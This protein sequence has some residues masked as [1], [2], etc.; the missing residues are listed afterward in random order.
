MPDIYDEMMMASSRI[1]GLFPQARFYTECNRELNISRQVF[2]SDTTVLRCL[3]IVKG[4][5][6]D[7][8]GHGLEHATKV[9]V[10]A[11]ALALTELR[12]VGL[13]DYPVNRIGVLAQVTGLL[14]D[15]RR[16]EKDHA[17]K[18]ARAAEPIIETLFLSRHEQTYVIQAIANHEAF[19]E[20]TTLDSA[21][22]QVLSDVL[23]DA[24]KFRWGPDNFTLTLWEMLRS[25][26]VQ[27]TT[28]IE[29]FP[30]GMASIA[31]IRGTFRSQAG[32]RFG[33]E[34]I[35]VGLRIGEEI[36]RFLQERF[37]VRPSR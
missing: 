9:A 35:D 20:P 30:E 36:Y 2:A 37:A 32:K 26:P 31:R 23:Y 17:K 28:V 3:E 4:G 22:G 7:N 27:M 34:F 11:G 24:D 1:A 29:Q 10:E 13:C 6:N 12:T 14:H 5:L 15:I 25:R 16:G 19:I 33:P 18:S 21:Y 8:F